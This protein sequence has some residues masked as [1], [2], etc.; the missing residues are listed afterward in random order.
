ML[1]VMKLSLCCVIDVTI[2]ISRCY[3]KITVALCI[4]VIGDV[5]VDL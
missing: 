1:V 2:S 4:V 3:N 5:V